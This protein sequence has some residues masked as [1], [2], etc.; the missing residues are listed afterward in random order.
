MKLTISCSVSQRGSKTAHGNIAQTKSIC[1][2][3]GNWLSLSFSK[4]IPYNRNRFNLPCCQVNFIFICCFSS[5]VLFIIFLFSSTFCFSFQI[6]SVKQSI[7]LWNI[8]YF[9]LFIFICRTSLDTYF[10]IN[11]IFWRN[12][13]ALLITQNNKIMLHEFSNS[14]LL[15]S[16][17][18]FVAALVFEIQVPSWI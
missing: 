14:C 2:Y 9:I 8:L 3:I 4:G 6:V 7:I 16:L 11:S 13:K 17:N 15:I 1:E 10:A 18:L 5:S 12:A